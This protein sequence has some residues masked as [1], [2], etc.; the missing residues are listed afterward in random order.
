MGLKGKQ[1][2]KKFLSVMFPECYIKDPET[3]SRVIESVD[4][5][6]EDLNIVCHN[7]I[8]SAYSKRS[9]EDHLKLHIQ[10]QFEV[11]YNALVVVGTMDDPMHVPKCKKIEQ[12]VRD[13][14]NEKSGI[15]FSDFQLK[16][17]GNAAYLTRHDETSFSKIISIMRNIVKEKPSLK[18]KRRRTDENND[19]SSDSVPVYDNQRLITTEESELYATFL[20]MLMCTRRTRADILHFA[21][22][23]FLNT[24]SGCLVSG[25]KLVLDGVMWSVDSGHEDD[26]TYSSEVSPC[27]MTKS[28]IEGV[29]ITRNHPTMKVGE[30]DIKMAHHAM[31]YGE[32]GKT[33]WL[34]CSDTDMFVII[35]FTMK[36]LV[37]TGHEIPQIYYNYTAKS[38]IRKRK[39]S[40]E[41]EDFLQ[42]FVAKKHILDMKKLYYKIEQTLGSIWPSSRDVIN[43]L[44]V[45]M[46]ADGTDYVISPNGLGTKTFMKAFCAGGY[47]I[48]DDVLT[49][50]TTVVQGHE[51][52]SHKI[53]YVQINEERLY[54]YLK[55][56]YSI[57]KKTRVLQMKGINKLLHGNLYIPA[58]KVTNILIPVKQ[59]T[60]PTLKRT[61]TELLTQKKEDIEFWGTDLIAGDGF[62]DEDTTD[63]TKMIADELRYN[64][65]TPALR[66]KILKE[67]IFDQPT[68][69]SLYM[70]KKKQPLKQQPL[71]DKQ[72]YAVARRWAWNIAYWVFS[73][74]C[75]FSDMSMHK[76]SSGASTFGYEYDPKSGLFT[77]SDSL[78]PS[79]K[80]SLQSQ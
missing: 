53:P 44:C 26:K 72:L 25:R 29:T 7:V 32:Q 12:K 31:V 47:A 49:I 9:F 45:A 20:N 62:G 1:G 67:F 70:N 6:V 69:L 4:V 39:D 38:N 40:Q 11:F 41:Y 65:E 35:L 61:R 21:T 75:S 55:Y 23:Q 30:G 54:Q 63:I 8:S 27:L 15:I 77:F 73:F 5:V 59:K 58:E 3:L 24:P 34:N 13:N 60:K 48:L 50:G 10:E 33:I 66:D 28:D 37:T 46:M 43:T 51:R 14:K 68:L 17:L 64:G 79:D 71:S 52:E 16:R 2:W 76:D 36:E 22:K 19:D 78:E 80:T 42:N 57:L 18:K 74:R 56:T